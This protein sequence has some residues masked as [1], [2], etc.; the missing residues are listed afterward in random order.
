MTTK[1]PITEKALYQRINRKLKDQDASLKRARGSVETTLGEY[2]VVD[3]KGNYVTN[4]HIQIENL[5]RELGVLAEWET[6][7]ISDNRPV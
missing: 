4:H 6:L 2:F 3:V 1:V 5:G 7:Q